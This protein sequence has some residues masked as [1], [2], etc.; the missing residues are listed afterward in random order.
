M[1][2]LNEN[3]NVSME[4]LHG[5]YERDKKDGVSIKHVSKEDKT[6]AQRK[7]PQGSL[8][9][10]HHFTT[11]LLEDWNM[12]FNTLSQDDMLQKE[13]IKIWIRALSIN[14]SVFTYLSLSV[15]LT[16]FLCLSF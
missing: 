4:Y 16:Y 10:I 14:L 15:S 6:E 8:L 1:Q 2:W 3:D 5:A 12:K 7:L 13:G 11:L 9:I